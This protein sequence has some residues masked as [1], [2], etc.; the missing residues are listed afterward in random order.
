MKEDYFKAQNSKEEE[1]E[2]V[3]V[4]NSHLIFGE[5]SVYLDIKRKVNSQK[6][7]IASI[8]DGYVIS[9]SSGRPKLYVIENEISS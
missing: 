1:L 9:F 8:P 2:R 3:V 7:D 4:E 6:G 5:D